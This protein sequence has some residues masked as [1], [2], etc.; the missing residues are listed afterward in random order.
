MGVLPFLR[1]PAGGHRQCLGCSDTLLKKF[2]KCQKRR[3][4]QLHP[5]TKVFLCLIRNLKMVIW[6]FG[7]ELAGSVSRALKQNLKA[8]GPVS[9][10][11]HH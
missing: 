5:F 11:V 3:E 2:K 8:L 7:S 9:L 4:A 1:D 10:A 6:V